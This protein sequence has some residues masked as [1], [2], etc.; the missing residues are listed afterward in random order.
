[1]LHV[2]IRPSA[3]GGWTLPH[4]PPAHRNIRGWHAAALLLA[5]LPLP[6]LALDPALSAQFRQLE[7]RLVA[8]GRLR[9]EPPA[10]GYPD[11]RTLLR[12]FDRIALGRE[13]GAGSG[14]MRWEHPVTIDVMF[15]A[16]VPESQRAQ[17]RIHVA[18]YARQLS[19]RSG[20]PVR[21]GGTQ[22]NFTVFV[23]SEGERRGLS[24]HLTARAPG[25]ADRTKAMLVH[26]APTELCMVA[27]VPHAD[28]TQGYR[29]AVAVIR[30]E[31]PDR[32]LAACIEEEI[33]QGLGLSN[34]GREGTPSLFN[35][36][37]AWARLTPCDEQLLALLYHPHLRSGMSRADA[38][39]AAEAILGSGRSAFR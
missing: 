12:D 29:A 39:A 8:Q 22:P 3:P 21:L 28:R 18:R 10:H 31:L 32:L 5:C 36:N 38:M 23:V 6:A 7:H 1:V 2:S 35:D 33:A 14:L 20:H 30:A 9:E 16:S 27:A 11:A 37:A 19:S 34:D 26:M 24:T 17:V 13:Y 15:G 25:L 4:R